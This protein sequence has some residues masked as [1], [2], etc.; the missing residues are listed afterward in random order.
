MTT[1]MDVIR[2]NGEDIRVRWLCVC[3]CV[4][5]LVV[6]VRVTVKEEHE[7]QKSLLKGLG[8][9]SHEDPGVSGGRVGKQEQL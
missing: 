6:L 3:V 5:L 8:V 9:G 4:F 2:R 7:I 1:R